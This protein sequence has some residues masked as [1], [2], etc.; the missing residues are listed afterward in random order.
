MD[1]T[2]FVNFVAIDGLANGFHLVKNDIRP[3]LARMFKV[4]YRSL[5]QGASLFIFSDIAPFPRQKAFSWK[6]VSIL[7]NSTKRQ[8]REWGE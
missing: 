2:A 7:E 4:R 8:S 3:G 6:R 5:E 1:F